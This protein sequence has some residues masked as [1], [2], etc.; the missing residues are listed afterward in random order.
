[1]DQL[2]KRYADPFSFLNGYIQT[3]RLNWFLDQFVSIVNEENQDKYRWEF[4]LHK[5]F[6]K[7]FDDW[8]AEI[9]TTNKNQNM[10]KGD[11]EATINKAISILQNFT[12]S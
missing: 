8:N 7:S 1:M 4:Y 11:L 5:V 10:S 12:P 2:F 6:G 3:S 9:E